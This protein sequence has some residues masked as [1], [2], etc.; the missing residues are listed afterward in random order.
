MSSGL[1]SPPG[2]SSGDSYRSA[3]SASSFANDVS[4]GECHDSAGLRRSMIQ[5]GHSVSTRTR[6]SR[7]SSV[8]L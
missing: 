3:W 4:G 1:P 7:P 8:L 5:K 6:Y 2:R